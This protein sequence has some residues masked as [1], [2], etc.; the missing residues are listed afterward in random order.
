M[1]RS[2]EELVQNLNEVIK[3]NGIGE[4]TGPIL[5]SMLNSMIT[6]LHGTHY[7]HPLHDSVVSSD[8]GKL[9]MKD[10]ENGTAKVY[11]LSAVRNEQMGKWKIKILSNSPDLNGLLKIETRNNNWEIH[12]NQWLNGGSPPPTISAELIALRMYLVNTVGLSDYSY[13]IIG[14]TLFIDELIFRTST[15]FFDNSEFVELTILQESLPYADAAP[16]SY[17]L[18]KLVGITEGNM[19]M[20]S[21]APVDTYKLAG[22]V[23]LFNEIFDYESILQ[24]NINTG[25]RLAGNIVIPHEDGKVIAFDVDMLGDIDN[26]KFQ[27]IFRHHFVGLAI[28]ATADTVTVLNLSQYSL[29]LSVIVRIAKGGLEFNSR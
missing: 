9:M 24:L 5:N 7:L 13:N 22:S 18:G 11:N 8:V 16:T 12:R 26:T 28:H 15:F 17:P 2:K 6:T 3:A 21:C 27:T 20:I 4:I 1:D 29:I 14:D 25:F 10:R 23:D 19:G